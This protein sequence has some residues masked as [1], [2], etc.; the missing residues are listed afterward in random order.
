MRFEQLSCG[1]GAVITK[2]RLHEL[3]DCLPEAEFATAARVLGALSRPA[4]PFHLDLPPEDGEPETEEERRA[5]AEAKAALS[6]GDV[7]SHEMTGCELS[8]LRRGSCRSRPSRRGAGGCGGPATRGTSALGS[9]TIETPGSSIFG[10]RAAGRGTRS[11]RGEGA[12]ETGT[13][14]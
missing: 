9:G 6:R 1:E 14:R 3:V 12:T 4:G 10:I 5:V 2:E 7:V 8:W 11:M 13:R